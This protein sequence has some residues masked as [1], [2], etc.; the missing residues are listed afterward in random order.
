MACHHPLTCM[1]KIWVVR[2]APHTLVFRSPICT[3]L[4]HFSPV[5]AMGCL[6]LSDRFRRCSSDLWHRGLQGLPS[7]CPRCDSPTWRSLGSGWG[8]ERAISGYVCQPLPM[9]PPTGRLASRW[10]I[11]VI[12]FI[13]DGHRVAIFAPNPIGPPSLPGLLHFPRGD[14][15][16]HEP[17]P[18]HPTPSACLCCGELPW[19][20]S[21]L[22]EVIPAGRCHWA[23]CQRLLRRFD[24]HRRQLGNF[25]L[26]PCS[27]L[28]HHLH[29]GELDPFGHLQRLPEGPIQPE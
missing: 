7:T 22:D 29:Q 21:S 25:P 18:H 20:C 12:C 4:H 10:L 14:I 13:S 19:Q 17:H 27:L 6:L 24:D 23:L 2:W 3:L 11:L 9:A 16:P 15:H 26:V 1:Y 5:L 28:G 8:R